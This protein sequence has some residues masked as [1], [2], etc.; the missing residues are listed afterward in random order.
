MKIQQSSYSTLPCNYPFFVTVYMRYRFL[1]VKLA[2]I[3]RQEERK[4]AGDTAQQLQTLAAAAAPMSDGSNQHSF[5]EPYTQECTE[6]DRQTETAQRLLTQPPLWVNQ[7]GTFCILR[8][9]IL[10]TWTRHRCRVSRSYHLATASL[11]SDNS[12]LYVPPPH[13][14]GIFLEKLQ[15]ELQNWWM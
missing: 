1:P 7:A 3:K 5:R 9:S 6:T 11:C 14:A 10:I 13:H 4:G 12:P 15:H 8:C 2:M